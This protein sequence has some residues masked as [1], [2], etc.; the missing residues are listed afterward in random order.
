MIK[1]TFY[2]KRQKYTDIETL[3]KIKSA[4]IKLDKNE[5]QKFLDSKI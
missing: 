2:D 1:K 4:A 3:A 5:L